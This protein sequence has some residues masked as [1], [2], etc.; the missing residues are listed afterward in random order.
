MIDD[1]ALAQW[2][3]VKWCDFHCKA[4]WRNAKENGKDRYSNVSVYSFM[5][6][7][8]CR[9]IILDHVCSYPKG[10]LAVT[11]LLQY[12]LYQ[13]NSCRSNQMTRRCCIQVWTYEGRVAF[14]LSV[15][16]EDKPVSMAKLKLLQPR[17]AHIMN[18]DGDAVVRIWTVSS[19][20]LTHS[21]L[22]WNIILCS[23]DTLHCPVQRRERSDRLQCKRSTRPRLT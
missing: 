9:G 19:G 21:Y 23:T 22:H 15:T 13:N 11:P 14:V 18:D 12:S 1:A 5:I 2:S 10:N 16:E 3:S 17:L 8:S 6:F 7:L 20:L 4:I